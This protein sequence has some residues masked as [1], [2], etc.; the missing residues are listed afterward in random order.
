MATGASTISLTITGDSS[1]LDKATKAASG[2]VATMTDSSSKSIGKFTDAFGHSSKTFRGAGDLFKVAGDTAAAFGINL[3]IDQLVSFTQT[4]SDLAKGFKEVLNPAFD[5]ISE[6]LGLSKTATIEA[7]EATEAQG[8]ATDEAAV[9]QEGLNGAMD[10]NPIGAIILV[11]GLLVAA[12][13]ELY[14]HCTTFRDAINDAFSVAKKVTAAL[15]SGI[16]TGVADVKSAFGSIAGAVSGAFSAVEGIIGGVLNGAI[17]LIN[18]ALSGINGLIHA[19]NKIPFVS[20]PSIPPLGH[21]NLAKGGF[22]MAGQTA[23]VGELGPE[24]FTPAV[25]GYVSPAGSGSGDV[26]VHVTA[27]PAGLSQF[28]TATVSRDN[29]K[30]KLA[31]TAGARYRTG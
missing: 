11:I 10:A 24:T 28:I 18:D 25:P 2:S 8:A 5:K 22:L 16:K 26:H 6:K 31:A 12:F 14:K 3:P 20:I 23:T 7:T 1:G 15:W 13:V 27:D 30:T 29:G 21:V 9:S 4:G 17:D 19:A